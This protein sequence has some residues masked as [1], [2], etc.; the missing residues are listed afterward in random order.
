MKLHLLCRMQVLEHLSEGKGIAQNIIS[1]VI[2]Y[3][4]EAN[5]IKIVFRIIA[6]YKYILTAYL[7]YPILDF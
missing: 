1:L 7:L 5:T 2:T 4:T 6:E 3:K